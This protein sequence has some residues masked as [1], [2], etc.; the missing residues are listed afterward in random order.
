MRYEVIYSSL[1]ERARSEKR[2]K[3]VGTFYESHHIIPLCTGG[4]NKKHNLVLLTIRE[5]FLAHRLLDKIYRGAK[6]LSLAVWLMLHGRD[7]LKIVSSRGFARV[8]ERVYLEY[9][10]TTVYTNGSE[11]KRM[12]TGE[13]P[14]GW[15]HVSK[16]IKHK[17]KSKE[18]RSG[19]NHYKYDTT[20]YSYKNLFTGC[21]EIG[22]TQHEMRQKHN[23][24]QPKL[25]G[26]SRGKKKSHRGWTLLS[27]NE[28]EKLPRKCSSR[29]YK[30]DPQPYSFMNKVTG[31][32]EKDITQ[33]E[34]K[35]K[36]GLSSNL[37]KI[38]NGTQ[39]SYKNWI[40]IP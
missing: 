25:S 36:Y 6:G 15:H 5:H 33:S 12:P 29:S 3:G 7:G 2:S 21:E 38:L 8:K 4:S 40:L 39:K 18:K 11:N 27:Y 37:S 17:Q 23:L 30:R 28:K 14:E 16:G 32:V 26:V 22:I 20:L 34:M 35:A 19:P 9:V 1:I 31:E 10:G 24:S 13:V